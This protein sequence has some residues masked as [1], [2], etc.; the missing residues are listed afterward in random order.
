MRLFN[1]LTLEEALTDP[2][3]GAMMRA[4][5]VTASDL[6]RSFAP[7]VARRRDATSTR[8]TDVRDHTSRPSSVREDWP[9]LLA[10]CLCAT[11]LAR[12]PGRPG[13]GQGR[14]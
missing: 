14:L 10:D 1:D 7:L 3:I 8:R 13:D 11:R 2:I 9:S 12:E 4:D 5:G 6:R